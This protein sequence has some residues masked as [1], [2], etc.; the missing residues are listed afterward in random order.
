MIADLLAQRQLQRLTGLR[1]I[2]IGVVDILRGQLV[3]G[4]GDIALSRDNRIPSG[5]RI[6]GDGIGKPRLVVKGDGELVEIDCPA[7]GL[8]LE[9]ESERGGRGI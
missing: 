1:Q 9:G 7:I 5:P 3:V 4:R 8:G 6:I 2:H